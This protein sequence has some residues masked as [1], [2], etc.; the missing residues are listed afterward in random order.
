MSERNSSVSFSNRS[1]FTQNIPHNECSSPIQLEDSISIEVFGISMILNSY[2]KNVSI[3]I[4]VYAATD[5]ENYVE[6]SW[7]ESFKLHDSNILQCIF[8]GFII[9]I[10]YLKYNMN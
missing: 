2:D 7:M 8:K 10:F 4:K 9:M 1:S 6:T 5:L 3:K